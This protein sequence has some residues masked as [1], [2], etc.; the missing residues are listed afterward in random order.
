MSPTAKNSETSTT[1]A[2]PETTATTTNYRFIGNHAVMFVKDNGATPPVGVGD[3]IDLTQ[4]EFDAAIAHN[5]DIEQFL[6]T[7]S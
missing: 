5:P 1:D 3:Y 2:A 7:T 4:T 6:I